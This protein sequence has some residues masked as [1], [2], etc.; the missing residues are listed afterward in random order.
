MCSTQ[1]ADT[2][3]NYPGDGAE[4]YHELLDKVHFSGDEDRV[5]TDGERVPAT[6][7]PPEFRVELGKPSQAD[8]GGDF[9]LGKDEAP[10]VRLRPP[11]GAGQVSQVSPGP[12]PAPPGKPQPQPCRNGVA[13]PCSGQQGE[14][15]AATA[16]GPFSQ[17][18]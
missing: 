11:R 7:T 6:P 10:G 9:S 2:V 18:S 13:R 16:P 17:I 14:E 8:A 3:D 5:S 15:G 4:N 1:D 12:A